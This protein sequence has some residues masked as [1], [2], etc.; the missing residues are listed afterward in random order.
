MESGTRKPL[1][2]LAAAFVLSTTLGVVLGV[3]GPFGSYL[4]GDLIQR[5]VYWTVS[6]WAGWL[7]FGLALSNLYR[8]AAGQGWPLWA[9]GPAAVALLTIPIAAITRLLVDRILS[10]AGGVGWLEW[11][12]QCLIISALVSGLVLWRVAAALR[13][14][15]SRGEAVEEVSSPD[16]ADPRD[17]LPRGLG[18]EVLCLQM[19]DHYVRVHTPGGSAL[20]LM[21]L[22][23]AVAGLGD[24]E[25]MQTHRSWW[26]ARDAVEGAVEDGRNL[27]LKL[28]GG[29]TAPVSRARVGALRAAGWLERLFP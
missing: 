15:A 13:R 14:E 29:L 10:G 3:I 18:R 16:S 20:V 23:Q 2:T 8:M 26:V 24:L 6:L 5:V 25:G 4:S 12:G 11:Y 28:K 7:L 19:E 17:R 22:G 9:W 1:S 27:R 21:S